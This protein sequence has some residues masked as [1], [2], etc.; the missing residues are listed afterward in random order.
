MQARHCTCLTVRMPAVCMIEERKHYECVQRSRQKYG[1]CFRRPRCRGCIRVMRAVRMSPKVTSY[2]KKQIMN[3]FHLQVQHVT[4]NPDRKSGN[5]LG[6]S[7]LR[8]PQF[9]FRFRRYIVVQ[10][11]LA[12]EDCLDGSASHWTGWAGLRCAGLRCAGEHP[13]QWEALPSKQSSTVLFITL[14]Y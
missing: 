4:S 12:V 2:T 10:S 3:P 13:V 14:H 11:R 1:D 5:Q 6:I 7:M 9:R 8:V